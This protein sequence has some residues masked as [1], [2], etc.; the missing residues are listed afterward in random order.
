[1]EVKRVIKKCCEQ[2][3]AHRYDNLDE[4]D[5]FLERHKLSKLTQ[6]LDDL[7]RPRSLEEIKSIINSL[8]KQKVP[9]LYGFTSKFYQTFKEEIILILY[10]LFQ[11]VEAEGIL[12]DSFCEASIT[13]IS[14]PDYKETID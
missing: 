10:Y 7:N 13:L 12:P 1:M 2:F 5:Q 6:E 8:P 4:M 14:K 3:C 9:G 11:K